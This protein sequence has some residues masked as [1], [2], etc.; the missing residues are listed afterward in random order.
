MT[1]AITDIPAA[2]VASAQANPTVAGQVNDPNNPLN[3]VSTP[4]LITTSSASRSSYAD[5][6]TGLQSSLASTSTPT[7]TTSTPDSNNSSST[8]AP[9]VSAISTITDQ[10]S[11]PK[12][13]T[14]TTGLTQDPSSITSVS[15]NSDGTRVVSYRDGT[16]QTVAADPSK[17][18]SSNSTSPVSSTDSEN[19][20]T[21]SLP[22]GL[23]AQFKQTLAN[24]DQNIANAQQTLATAAATMTN[25]PAAASAA[26][27]I[28]TQYDVLIN[29]M[30]AK[31]AIVLGGYT[32]NAARSGGLQYANDMT[33]NFMSEE[34]DRASQRIADLVSKEQTLILASNNAYKNGDIKAFNAA[35]TALEK[36][37]ND[38]TSTLGK[39]LTATNNQVKNVQAQQKI[40]AAATKQQLA[41][42]TTTSTKIAAGMVA[43][44]KAAGISDP[45]TIEEYVQ[46]MA[47][48]NGITNP[49]ILSGALA[50]AQQTAAKTDASLANT[51]STIAK[52]GAGGTTGAKG[53]TDGGYTY[54]AADVAVYTSLLNKG[55]TAPDGTKYN[56]RGTD[57]YVD[58]G[59]Y[60]AAYADWVANNGTPAG[61]L[62]KFPV[63]Q[64]NPASI[65]NLPAA[66]QPKAKV[67]AATNAYPVTGK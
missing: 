54:T 53:G 38:K 43:A 33:E 47:T 32:K 16:S 22:P 18:V 41:S 51:A 63:S 67:A 7:T 11:F 1:G 8:K 23:A 64:V 14:F 5:N 24:Q 29:A 58:P 30:K 62:K 34:M 6:V 19:D 42:D 65:P 3:K 55:G 57:G 61:F 45:K 60:A 36:T 26:A 27:A 17:P 40:D 46:A 52:R 20:S 48:K 21:S 59:A 9:A 10:T 56:A 12:D 35:Q 31:N 44:L 28:K 49:D 50:T 25:D 2:S 15:V 37:Q 66:L 13:T 39:L 4:A